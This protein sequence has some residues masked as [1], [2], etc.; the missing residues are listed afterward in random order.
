MVCRQAE[1]SLKRSMLRLLELLNKVWGLEGCPL[2]GQTMR[3]NRSVRFGF[4]GST[5]LS[6][7]FGD[8]VSFNTT[9]GGGVLLKDISAKGNSRSFILFRRKHW[10]LTIRKL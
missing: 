1:Y 7:W 4:G 8:Q 9:V 10:L 6:A 5:V 3:K 2:K